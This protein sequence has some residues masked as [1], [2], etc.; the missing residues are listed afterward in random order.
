[1]IDLQEIEMAVIELI[2]VAGRIGMSLETA[3]GSPFE[4]PAPMDGPWAKTMFARPAR[5]RRGRYQPAGDSP[6]CRGGDGRPFPRPYTSW[7]CIT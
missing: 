1:M 5:H 2:K 6:L 4:E 7:H 3:A